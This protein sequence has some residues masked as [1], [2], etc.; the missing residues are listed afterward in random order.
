MAR[1]TPQTGARFVA[2]Q[3]TSSPPGEHRSSRLSGASQ[4]TGKLARPVLPGL[5]DRPDR[6]SAAPE[7]HSPRPHTR[8]EETFRSSNNRN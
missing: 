1:Y 7:V 8:R 2:N 3:G 4:N 5:A 6:P